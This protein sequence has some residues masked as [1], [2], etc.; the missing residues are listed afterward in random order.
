MWVH[1]NIPHLVP[2]FKKPFNSV[3]CDQFILNLFTLKRH[4]SQK[5]MVSWV[6]F[7]ISSNLERETALEL[8]ASRGTQSC[9]VL[10]KNKTNTTGMSGWLIDRTLWPSCP[11][12]GLLETPGGLRYFSPASWRSDVHP[13][14]DQALYAYTLQVALNV[15]WPRLKLLLL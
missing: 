8:A 9:C 10:L 14:F 3:Q 12:L 1:E 2:I 11:V 6:N 13:A 5:Q 7:V 4:S 15:T